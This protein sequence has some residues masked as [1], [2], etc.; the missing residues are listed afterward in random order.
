MSPSLRILLLLVLVLLYLHLQLIASLHKGVPIS[1]D[2]VVQHTE[3][4]LQLGSR[5]TLLQQQ[6]MVLTMVISL[7]FVTVSLPLVIHCLCLLN[8]CRR[9]LYAPLE[10]S[11]LLE[12]RLILLQRPIA[13][14]VAVHQQVQKTMAAILI[15]WT[16]DGL[17]QPGQVQ[18]QWGTC[19]GGGKEWT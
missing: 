17:L 11:V 10:Q 19:R 12:S 3:A 6:H 18:Q 7:R 2:A 16:R 9:L 4:C 15:S 8:L 14:A 13:R 1:E 5:G